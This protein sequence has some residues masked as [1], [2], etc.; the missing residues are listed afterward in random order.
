MDVVSQN[1]PLK[2][3]NLSHRDF[4]ADQKTEPGNVIHT[5]EKMEETPEKLT[6]DNECGPSGIKAEDNN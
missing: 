3:E 4:G 6:P 2:V 5:Q 1:E